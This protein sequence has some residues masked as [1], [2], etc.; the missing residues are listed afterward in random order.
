[1]MILRVKSSRLNNHFPNIYTSQDSDRNTFTFVPLVETHALE[2]KD[3]YWAQSNDSQRHTPAADNI[4]CSVSITCVQNQFCCPFC[5]VWLRYGRCVPFTFHPVHRA[6]CRAFSRTLA[7]WLFIYSKFKFPNKRVKKRSQFH[8]IV[9]CYWRFGMR[10]IA[11]SKS[12]F[13]YL[14]RT[15]RNV[16]HGKVLFKKNSH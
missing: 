12:F 4:K 7:A 1:M 6:R 11:F 10:S 16:S 2:K 9:Y 14:Q 13:G 8:S 5:I 3:F 15:K